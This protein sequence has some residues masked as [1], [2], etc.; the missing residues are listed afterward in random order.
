MNTGRRQIVGLLCGVLLWL[1]TP[2]SS[3]AQGQ[4]EVSR[5]LSGRVEV[6]LRDVEG[7]EM[8]GSLDRLL[9]GSPLVAGDLSRVRKL[10]DLI[11]QELPKYGAFSRY[12]QLKIERIG[13]SLVRCVYLYHCKNYPVVW[14]FTFYKPAGKPDW[15]VIALK[16]D[17]DYDKL[18]ATPPKA[19]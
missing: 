3:R 9:T 11:Q 2:S 14:Y 8:R 19:E 18:P 17:V 16:F 6:F 12:E 7:D 1:A 4:D 5:T 13:T 15:V 10:Q